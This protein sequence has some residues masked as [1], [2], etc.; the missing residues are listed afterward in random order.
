MC[1]E[2]CLNVKCSLLQGWS[3]SEGISVLGHPPD[4]SLYADVFFVDGTHQWGFTLPFN[5]TITDKW[6]RVHGVI[7]APSPILRIELFCMLRWR[8]GAAKFSDV[9]ITRLDDGICGAVDLV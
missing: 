2:C 9:K 7:H 6:Q 8:T 3:L 5:P 4:Y 1:P